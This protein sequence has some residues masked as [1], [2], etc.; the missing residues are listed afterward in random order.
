[1]KCCTFDIDCSQCRIYSGGWSSKFEPRPEDLADI[2]AFERWLDMV[3]TA[4]RIFVL[5]PRERADM[6][7]AA[8]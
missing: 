8:E 7:V 1:M 6:P 4:G 5:E 2:T 3:D